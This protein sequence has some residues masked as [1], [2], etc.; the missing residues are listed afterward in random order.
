MHQPTA[1]S[2]G[3]AYLY[4]RHALPV[5]IM[6]WINVIAL[7]ILFMSGLNIFSAHPDLYWGKSSY[8]QRPAIL[9][10]GSVSTADNGIA[11]RTRIFGHEF[12]TTGWLGA[13]RG[14]DGELVE[15]SFPSWMHASMQ[16]AAST[17]LIA[18]A[19]KGLSCKK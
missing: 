7:T 3:A 14:P 18:A 13:T 15:R 19:R 11:G 5:R 4:Y 6:H 10:I 12:D 16:T 2:K 8:S 1:A 17:S 9:Q